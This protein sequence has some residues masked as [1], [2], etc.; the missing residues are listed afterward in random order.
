M[1]PVQN[2]GMEVPR[3]T[4]AVAVWSKTE[5]RRT[6][7][8]MP[9]GMREAEGDRHREHGEEQRRRHAREHE[10]QGR[11]AVEEGVAEVAP[12]DVADEAP[13]LDGAADR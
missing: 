6:A 1:M 3:N 9:M 13:E 8:M 10:R 12:R 5:L 4:T 7:L 11:L 2:T